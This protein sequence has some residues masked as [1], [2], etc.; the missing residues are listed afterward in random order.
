MANGA[1]V[2]RNDTV[3]IA[4]GIGIILVV[5]AHTIRGL[6]A[7]GLL[8]DEIYRIQDA[9]IYS[10]HMPLF[11][12]LSGL[13]VQGGMTRST[14]SFVKGRFQSIIY[15][16]LLW[17]IV[18]TLVA[19]FAAPGSP[20]DV[21]FEALARIAWDPLGHFWFL[22][23]LLFCH[24]LLFLFWRWKWLVIALAVA[25]LFKPAL[26]LPPIFSLGLY[27]FTF[28]AAGWLVA[29]GVVPVRQWQRRIPAYFSTPLIGAMLAVIF[30]LIFTLDY[31]AGDGW[32]RPFLYWLLAITG[33]AMTMALC[34][35]LNGRAS[36]IALVGQCSMAVY[37]LHI[38][39]VG[40]FRAVEIRLGLTDPAFM[41]LTLTLVGT[42][43]PILFNAM[44][45]ATGTSAWFGLPSI[46]RFA[47]RT[48]R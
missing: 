39:I 18:Q 10:F 29:Q 32:L 38:M 33:I 11:F 6:D 22:Y 25:G 26:P 34:A 31:R 5:Y 12:F 7:R 45:S 21:G 1:T 15:P 35:T 37:I 40:A 16:Y 46:S 13:F 28:V 48:T 24:V 8:N 43:L 47:R 19:R 9:A 17:S 20:S 41:L 36:M 23:V 44:T 27:N 14:R 2:A 42:V 30:L 4:R 3:D